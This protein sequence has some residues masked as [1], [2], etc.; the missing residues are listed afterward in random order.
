MIGPVAF[1]VAPLVGLLIE[2]LLVR[3]RFRPYLAAGLPLAR[4]LVP[5]PKPPEGEGSTASV[6]WVADEDG[7]VRWWA[8]GSREGLTG[9]HGVVRCV[10]GRHGVSLLVRW[11][12]PW[13]P[14]LAAVGLAGFGVARG[15]PQVTIPVGLAMVGGLFFVY[16]QG[17][18]RAAAE[19]RWSFVQGGGADETER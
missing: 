15:L 16:H 2:L 3:L 14:L 7:V 1:A 8:N 17:A 6:A 12:P 13:S 19:L 18:V 9:L 10:R 4:E 5:I 11:S